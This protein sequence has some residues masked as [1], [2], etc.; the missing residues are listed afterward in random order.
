M[1]HKNV[2]RRRRQFEGLL[3][4]AV[5]YILSNKDYVSK[6]NTKSFPIGIFYG[7]DRKLTILII[8]HF[9]SGIYF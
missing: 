6:Y 9:I 4:N 8:A 7:S 2:D 3:I 1:M 5:L